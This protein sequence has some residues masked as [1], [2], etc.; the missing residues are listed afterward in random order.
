M[1][2]FQTEDFLL[3]REVAGRDRVDQALTLLARAY[4]GEPV[5]ALRRLPLGRRN[6]RLLTLR[7]QLFGPL[8]E[9]FAA[10]P[11]CGQEVE[12]ALDAEAFPPFDET[13]TTELA[14]DG[15]TIR[16]RLL[17]SSDLQAASRC[18]DVS[19]A[20]AVLLERCVVEARRGGEPVAADALPPEVVEHLAER[21][22]ECD[23]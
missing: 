19:E 6:A 14:V 12:L 22:E 2:A 20:R 1:T 3:V 13:V 11:H 23:P 17:D 4:P 10:C 7:K 16:F 15:F 5:E 9:A 18:G 8:L 21:L